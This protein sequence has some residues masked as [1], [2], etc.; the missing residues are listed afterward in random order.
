MYHE[1]STV[2][3]VII[4]A[5]ALLGGLIVLYQEP[6]VPTHSSYHYHTAYD[7]LYNITVVN[8]IVIINHADMKHAP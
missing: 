1:I 4:C 6:F 2:F 7:Y 3:K 5:L 8:L